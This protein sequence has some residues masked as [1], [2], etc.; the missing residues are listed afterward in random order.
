MKKYALKYFIPVLIFSW[1]LI[2][3]AHA[4]SR[5]WIYDTADGDSAC[6]GLWSELA[7]WSGTSGGSK[8]TTG[9]V[10]GSSDAV[11]FYSN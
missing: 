6:T 7:C 8:L 2:S 4:A 3:E 5:F 9:S 11:T 10:P 1:A